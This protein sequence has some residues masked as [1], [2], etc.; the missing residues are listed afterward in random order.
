MKMCTFAKLD[1]HIFCWSKLANPLFKLLSDKNKYP[2]TNTRHDNKTR[3]AL[4]LT[5]KS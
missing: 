1:L 3:P 2:L 4:K 5:G